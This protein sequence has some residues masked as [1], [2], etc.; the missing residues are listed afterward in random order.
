MT[1]NYNYHDFFKIFFIFCI[2]SLSGCEL[3]NFAKDVALVPVIVA[4][5]TLGT[6]VARDINNGIEGIKKPPST[7]NQLIS[8][9]IPEMKNSKIK[10]GLSDWLVNGNCALTFPHEMVKNGKDGDVPIVAT[11]HFVELEKKYRAAIAQNSNSE[12]VKNSKFTWSGGCNSNGR[13]EGNGVLS[14]SIFDDYARTWNNAPYSY[15]VDI[16]GTMKDGQFYGKMESQTGNS[17]PS[18]PG[19][20]TTK[21]ITSYAINGKFFFSERDFKEYENPSLKDIRLVE[22]ERERKKEDQKERERVAKLKKF[23]KSLS[24]GA[25]TSNGVVVDMKGSLVKIQTD[26]SQC[27]QRDYKDNCVNYVNTPSEKWFKRSEVYPK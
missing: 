18:A 6:H 26:E 14:A 3:V 9:K 2:F 23:Q 13:T 25:D 24:V 4:D 7:T 5:V 15:W 8:E 12:I 11:N 19:R 1:H 17:N 22:E 20:L 16:N 21:V 27:T 10:L